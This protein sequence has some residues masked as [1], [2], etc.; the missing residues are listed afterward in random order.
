MIAITPAAGYVS[1]GS[2]A[3][4]GVLAGAVCYGAVLFKERMD[5]DDALD[6][7]AVHGV[8]G[9]LGSILTGVFASPKTGAPPGLIF[10]ETGLFFANLGATAISMVY[11]F[12]MTWIVLKVIGWIKRLKPE[13]D[14]LEAGLDLTFHGERALDHD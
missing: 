7:W 6:V 10:G 2:A 8:G 1:P 3:I 13:T 11:A 12:A 4:I 9:V 14:E 5:W